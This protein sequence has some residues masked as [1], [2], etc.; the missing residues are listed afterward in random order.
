MDKKRPIFLDTYVQFAYNIFVE[1]Y[2]YLIFFTM[3]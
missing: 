1:F 3:A 2:K